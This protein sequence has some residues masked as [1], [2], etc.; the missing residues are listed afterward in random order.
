[1]T[2]MCLKYELIYKQ[3][4]AYSYNEIVHNK[5]EQITNTGNSIYKS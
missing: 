2:N 4:M 5:N 1:M 3:I